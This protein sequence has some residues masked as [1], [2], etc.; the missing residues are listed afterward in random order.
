MPQEPATGRQDDE[1]GQDGEPANADVR[2]WFRPS[3]LPPIDWQT[4]SEG[5]VEQ[6][7]VIVGP[8]LDGTGRVA[9]SVGG[10]SSEDEVVVYTRAEWEAFIGG[11]KDGEFDF[12]EEDA[13]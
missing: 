12:T 13:E 7:E 9:M 10:S 2:G 11:V 8:L 3:E 1:R 6:G 5:P 4:G